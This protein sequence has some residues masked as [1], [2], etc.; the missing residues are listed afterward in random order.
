MSPEQW[1]DTF[2]SEFP[3]GALVTFV[4]TSEEASTSDDS[5]QDLIADVQVVPDDD[6]DENTAAIRFFSVY[7][8]RPY[9][10]H[11]QN[12][13][14]RDDGVYLDV[15]ESGRQ[16]TGIKFSNRLSPEMIAAIEDSKEW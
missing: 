14:R 11:V 15:V 5:P 13:Q 9:D 16:F 4:L 10:L 6:N 3:E 8:D 7:T 12:L 2:D 1:Q